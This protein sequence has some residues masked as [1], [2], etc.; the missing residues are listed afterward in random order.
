MNYSE[1]RSLV[2]AM[3]VAQKRYFKERSGD[4]LSES[5]RLEHQVDK[6]LAEYDEG[7]KN[8]LECSK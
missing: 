5:K 8:F 6:A 1:F 3:R 7:Q 4:A 2:N